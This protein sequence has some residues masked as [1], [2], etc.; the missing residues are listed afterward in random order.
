MLSK[1]LLI[2]IGVDMLAGKNSFRWRKSAAQSA[3]IASFH[4]L[5][6][7]SGQAVIYKLF[8]L[9]NDARPDLRKRSVQCKALSDELA[10]RNITS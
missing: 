6:I 3:R 5:A 1:K 9:K 10:A 4:P 8:H 2:S 7:T